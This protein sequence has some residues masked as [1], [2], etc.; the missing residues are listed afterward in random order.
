MIVVVFFV[1]DF[2]IDVV[3]VDVKINSI[4]WF[5]I[6]GRKCYNLFGI[7]KFDV[8][9]LEGFWVYVLILFKG[10]GF[11]VMREMMSYG[12]WSGRVFLIGNVFEL[13]I[14]YN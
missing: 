11:F 12:L 13:L 2:L 8:V 4:E 6:V 3:C 10:L 7:N 1:F 9:D 14:V 5:M